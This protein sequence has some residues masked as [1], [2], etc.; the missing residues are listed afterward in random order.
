[1][2]S[3]PITVLSSGV[4]IRS[5][6]YAYY[7]VN[8]KLKMQSTS[9]YLEFYCVFSTYNS[10]SKYN[11]TLAL[12]VSVWLEELVGCWHLALDLG[13]II[14]S[15]CCCQHE[16]SLTHLMQNIDIVG[17]TLRILSIWQKHAIGQV[18]VPNPCLIYLASRKKF[19]QYIDEMHW[20]INM[21]R[22]SE[23]PPMMLRIDLPLSV[24]TATLAWLLVHQ[25][26]YRIYVHSIPSLDLS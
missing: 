2:L 8:I 4:N 10:S 17:K 19:H 11:S 6:M 18:K 13:S 21:E 7:P 9:N 23:L 16:R 25:K 20:L 1:M 15:W 5:L 26:R 3:L 12:Q 22:I 24:I 14:Q